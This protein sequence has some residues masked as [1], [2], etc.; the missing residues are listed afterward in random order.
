MDD[1]KRFDIL[2][3]RV[4][5]IDLAQAC[6]IIDGFIA[7]KKKAYVCVAPVSTIISCQEDKEYCRVVNEADMVTPDGMP[8]V[9]FARMKG[10]RN[11]GRT[12]G[13]DLMLAMCEEGLAKGYKH[14]FYGGMEESSRRLEERLRAQFPGI[15]V[16]GRQAPPFRDLSPREE[17]E[18]IEKINQAE[19]DIL[20][21]GLGSPKQDFWMGRN[22]GKLNASI[23]IGVGAAFDFLSGKKPQAPRWMQRSGLE[24]LFRL[25]CEPRRLWRRYLIG[26]TKFIYLV[27]KDIFRQGWSNG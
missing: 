16:A 2:G 27:I 11:V 20:W 6:A 1:H 23:L 12:Y 15:V 21:I 13:P 17:Q 24:W 25:C 5:A 3:V 22:R 26:N 7:H 14:Y 18:A 10:H 9:W 8:V 19:P 4:S